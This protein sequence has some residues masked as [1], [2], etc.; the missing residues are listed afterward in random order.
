M[1]RVQPLRDAEAC[2]N[3]VSDGASDVGDAAH[4]N[5]RPDHPASDSRQDTGHQRV[6]KK[7]KIAHGS[8]ELDH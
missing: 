4:Y 7:G 5:V 2:K 8:D 6:T 1:D 3:A